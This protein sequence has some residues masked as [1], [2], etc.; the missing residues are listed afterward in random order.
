MVPSALR[1]S[2][3]IGTFARD[4]LPETQ[5]VLPILADTRI[6]HYHRTDRGRVVGFVVQLEVEVAGVWRHAIRYDTSHGFAHIDRYRLSGGHTKERLFLRFKDALI[7]AEKDLSGN[8][9]AYRERFLRG[10]YP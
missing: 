5:Y 9:P 8:W 6:R 10:E 4:V 7:R 2:V 3:P 1:W